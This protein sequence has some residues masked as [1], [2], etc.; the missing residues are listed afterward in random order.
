M[1]K[2]SHKRHLIKRLITWSVSVV[3]L[4]AAA[5]I[6]IAFFIDDRPHVYTND[7]FLEGFRSDLSPD[8]LGRVVELNFDE[9]EFVK[10]GD[11]VAVL[12]Q[13]ILKSEREEAIA[14]IKVRGDEIARSEAHLNKIRNNYIRAVKGIKDQIISAQEFDHK[15]KDFHMAEASFQKALSDKELAD[16]KLEVIDTYLKHTYIHSPCDGVVAKRWVYLGDVLNP[17]QSLYTVYNVNEV[18]VQANLSETKIRKVVMGARVEVSVDA[19]PGVIFEGEVFSI[20][21]AAASQF[22][23]IPPNNATGNYTKV[24]QRIPIKISIK[25]PKALKDK[26]FYLFPGMN[27]EVKIFE[28]TKVDEKSAKRKA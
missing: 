17:G 6:G 28:Q 3:V 2:N 9:G 11:V 8:I 16:K 12:L 7:A 22:S 4:G 27:A 10:K 20:F 1:K 14:L 18:W 5:W 25:P 21:G 26:T 15:E 13:D 19:Y 24:A 23:V